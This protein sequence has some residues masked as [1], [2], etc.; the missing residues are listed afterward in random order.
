MMP[1]SVNDKKPPNELLN[2]KFEE[3]NFKG[4]LTEVN[5]YFYRSGW[6]DD[7]PIVPPTIQA[8]KEML[9][10]TEH[11]PDDSI[12]VLQ[13]AHGIATIRSIAING[14]MAGCKPEFMPVLETIVK[15]LA[16][17]RFGIQYAGSTTRWTPI[18]ILNGPIIKELNFN[19]GQ[20]VLRLERRANISIARD[21]RR[22]MSNIAGYRTGLTDMASFG[23]NYIPVLAEAEDESPYKSL[24]VDLG[25]KSSENVVSVSSV[26]KISHQ[27]VNYGKAEDHLRL[28]AQE[29]KLAL[30]VSRI[31][32]TFLGQK[33][34]H[35]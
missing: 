8:V 12:G 31:Q 20:G 14:V 27:F 24:S 2:K 34:F 11:S 1:S 26:G 4:S 28:I 19:S 25:Y 22:M 5:E 18:T 17:S 32:V 16:D 15:A 10:Y 9:E 33:F 30:S 13:P 3:I 21:L 23:Q 6:K 29:M 7:L 35:Y